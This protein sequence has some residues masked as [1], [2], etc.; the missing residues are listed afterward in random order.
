VEASRSFPLIF[1]MLLC[2]PLRQCLSTFL[3]IEAVVTFLPP[4]KALIYPPPSIAAS[5]VFAEGIIGH[6]Q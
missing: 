3:K 2:S 1:N 4:A 5:T 6:S